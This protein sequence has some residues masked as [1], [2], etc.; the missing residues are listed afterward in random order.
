[1]IETFISYIIDTGKEREEFIKRFHDVEPDK[2]AEYMK[3]LIL[4][5]SPIVITYTR[6][7]NDD[8]KPIAQAN[9]VDDTITLLSLK[10]LVK[11]IIAEAWKKS[12]NASAPDDSIQI[13]LQT[14]QEISYLI[15]KL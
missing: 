7:L 2:M 4:V 14:L 1:M 11:R 8:K 6:N 9:F 15:S 10:P 13:L 5:H 12:E 3:L